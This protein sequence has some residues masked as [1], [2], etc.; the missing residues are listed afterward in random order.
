MKRRDFVKNTTLGAVGVPF[1]LNGLHM[2]TVLKKLFNY[3]KNAEDRVLVL[4]R[5]NGGNDGLNTIIPL[6]QYDNL[7]IQ[8]EN[9]IIP[10]NQII[11]LGT[12]YLGM[13]PV[14]TGMADMFNNGKL[15]IIQNVGYPQQNRSHFKSM[16]IWT[17]GNVDSNSATGWLGRYF[18]SYNPNYPTGYPNENYPHPFAISMGYE[19]STTCQGIVSNYSLAVQDP[20]NNTDLGTNISNPEMSYYGNH[21]AYIESIINQSNVYGVHVADAIDAGNTLSTLYDDDNF[22]AVQLRNVAQLISGGLQTKIYVLNINGFDTHDSQVVQGNTTEGMHASLMKT[23]SDAIAAFQDDLALLGIE[24]KVLGMTF[25]EFGRQIASNASFGTDHGDAAPLFVFGSC[26]DAPIIGDNPEILDQIVN[27]KG[28]DMQ[29][30]FR[31]VYASILHDWFMVSESDVQTMFEHQVSLFPIARSCN[32]PVGITEQML[33]KTGTYCYPN[34]C[35]E[36]TTIV[37]KS[38]N[39]RVTLT[40]IDMNGRVVKTIFQKELV[41]QEHHVKIDVN[42]LQAGNYFYVVEKPSGSVKGR[43]QKIAI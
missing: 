7:V 30:D 10:D 42:D 35:K 18:D 9:I 41:S 38:Q 16:D 17:S 2:N 37:F 34:P 5:L 28:M 19:V 8:R 22:L 31:D 25:S 15:S 33:E 21:L 36:M 27:Q 24:E 40:V 12:N 1:A 26:I 39:E 43:F 20:T 3:N 11:N 13:H 4:I 23:V 6:D 14:M 29:Y 32:G